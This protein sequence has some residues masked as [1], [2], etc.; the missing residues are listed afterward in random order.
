MSEIKPVVQVVQVQRRNRM[1]RVITHQLVITLFGCKYCGQEYMEGKL[2]LEDM[3]WKCYQLRSTPC[4]VKKTYSAD[5]SK[6]IRR[7]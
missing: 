7:F 4:N 3:C 1:Y 6:A 5:L 2:P